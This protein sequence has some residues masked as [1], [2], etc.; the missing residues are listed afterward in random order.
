[1]IAITING[2]KK[3][4]VNYESREYVLFDPLIAKDI[5]SPSDVA[6]CAN[7]TRCYGTRMIYI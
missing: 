7:R 6:S 2:T 5:Y 1:M 4:Y 3:N